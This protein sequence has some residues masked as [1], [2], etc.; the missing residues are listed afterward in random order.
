[1]RLLL[2]GVH[3]HGEIVGRDV[4][5]IEYLQEE[6]SIRVALSTQLTDFCSQF[7]EL[8]SYSLVFLLNKLRELS[9]DCSHHVLQSRIERGC[10]VSVV[11]DLRRRGAG[12]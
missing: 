2:H 12:S 1:M 4:D 3:E 7:V 9:G 5:L 10:V 6:L 11:S 8:P